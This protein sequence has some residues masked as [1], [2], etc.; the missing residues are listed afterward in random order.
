MPRLLLCLAALL[1][2]AAAPL[3]AREQSEA[4]DAAVIGFSPD[5]R[6]FAW[7]EY[8][9]DIAS[10]ALSAAIHVV[11]RETNRQ[12]DGFPFGVVPGGDGSPTLLGGFET[13]LDALTDEPDMAAL[14]TA[15]RAGAEAKLSALAVGVPGRRLAGVPLTQ[16]SPLDK[17]TTPLVFV[18]H[19]T[20]PSA[21]PDQQLVYTLEARPS[22]EPEDCVN[23]AP[24]AREKSVEFD[25]IGSRTWPELKD[26]ARAAT[27]YS[28][29]M[30]AQ[31]CAAG[32]WIADI[33][34]PPGGADDAV[35][36]L[37]LAAAW[38]SAVDSAAWH[39]LFVTLPDE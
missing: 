23:A 4:P 25:V 38:N 1:T 2:L 32:L 11:D 19:P 17:K 36:V 21:I 30:P 5:G 26:V 31:D 39:G 12:A 14:R 8:G 7:E 6:Y 9:W 15:V 16:R 35:A 28:W 20:L 34:A 13:D 24:P 27:T 37:F 22:R 18:V 29:T 10:G 3:H 33:I